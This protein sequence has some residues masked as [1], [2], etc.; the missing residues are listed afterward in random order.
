MF[1][2]FKVHY[3]LG[4]DFASIIQKHKKCCVFGLGID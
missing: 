3:N 2:T 1:L 4:F